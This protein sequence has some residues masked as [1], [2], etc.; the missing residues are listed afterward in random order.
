MNSRRSRYRILFMV[1]RPIYRFET[2]LYER[3]TFEGLLSGL[4][5][6]A[7]KNT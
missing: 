6:E 2:R 1:W 4:V 5:D 7:G 3:F